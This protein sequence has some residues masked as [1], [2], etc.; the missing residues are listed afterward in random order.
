MFLSIHIFV[1][2]SLV[3]GL[4]L[5]SSFLP[6]SLPEGDPSEFALPVFL[7]EP[8]DT[9]ASRDTAGSLKCRAAHAKSVHF[10]CD[11]ADMKAASETQGRDEATGSSFLEVEI[12]VRKS[13]VLDTLHDFTC[14]CHATSAQGSVQSREAQVEIACE[15]YFCV[16]IGVCWSLHSSLGHVCIT[17]KLQTCRHLLM[18]AQTCN[19]FVYFKQNRGSEEI[20]CV[21]E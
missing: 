4:D 3:L 17:I 1:S 6:D 11:D 8:Q 2:A 19:R 5:T 20:N 7:Q 12:S 15:Y 13:H 18:T 10:T 14:V 16:N 21:A 9:F